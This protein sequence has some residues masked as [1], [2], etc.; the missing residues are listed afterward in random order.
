MKKNTLFVA[1]A[2][3]IISTSSIAAPYV[4][5]ARS[6]GMG[7]TGVVAADY[8]TAP[9]HNPAIGAMHR[10]N[11]DF[12]L[13]LPAIGANLNDQDESLSAVDDAQDAYDALEYY[14]YGGDYD[15]ALAN[16]QKLQASL[17]ALSDSA[18]VTVNA[19]VTTVIAIPTNILSVN[20]FATGYV[21]MLVMPEV[22]AAPNDSD[23]LDAIIS[24]YENSK[25]GLV[26]FSTAEVGLSFARKF[27]IAGQNFA[28]GVSPKV[29]HLL[30]YSQYVT[31]DSF[32]LDDY[33]SSEISETVFNMDIGA[34]WHKDA[35]RVGLTVKDLFKQEIETEIGG[36]TYELAPK[37]TLGI[38][39]V[40]EYC[41]LTLDADLTKQK[42]FQE[43]DG[44]DSQFV[45]VGIEGNA[46]GWAQL[47]AGY[48]IDLEDNLENS[49][50]AGIG[51]SPFDVFSLDIA[52][53]YAGENQLGVA[54]NLAFTF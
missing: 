32:D 21:E 1:G 47:R 7:N 22:A 29:Q 44:D 11:D 12:G 19:G 38:G 16:A 43:L 54:M 17:N 26:A 53:S 6:Q 4:A 40:G 41:T 3:S 18:P 37:A 34:L 30:T 5:D 13:L 51:L 36:L 48:E 27:D 50:T 14:S 39:Y 2:L 9:L 31:M 42:R 49:V 33:D 8:L 46:W 15:N 45:R 25:V 10:D 23:D 52:A 20:L 24:N 28:F 35:Y